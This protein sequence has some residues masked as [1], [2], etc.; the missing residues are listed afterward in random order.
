MRGPTLRINLTEFKAPLTIGW[1]WA[2]SIT[3]PSGNPS[4][5]LQV[6]LYFFHR[7]INNRI[8]HCNWINT[9]P[10]NHVAKWAGKSG[11]LPVAAW[12]TDI[13]PFAIEA[14]DKLAA[15]WTFSIHSFVRNSP[16]KSPN[17]NEKKTPAKGINLF[18]KFLDS[19]RAI[20]PVQFWYFLQ[21]HQVG[22]KTF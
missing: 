21:L 7:F 13:D 9:S 6:L 18:G 4:A 8:L 22:Y 3:M 5:I 11:S 17:Q 10:Q 12:G 19:R 20:L 14:G 16:I 15:V 2:F 1:G